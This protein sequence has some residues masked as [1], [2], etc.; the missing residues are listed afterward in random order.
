METMGNSYHQLTESLNGNEIGLSRF[1]RIR[2]DQEQRV[3]LPNEAQ[4]TIGGTESGKQ[5]ED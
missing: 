1:V 5:T 4:G 3:F 2:M